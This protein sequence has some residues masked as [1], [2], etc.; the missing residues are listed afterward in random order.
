MDQSEECGEQCVGQEGEELTWE[1]EISFT[2]ELTTEQKDPSYEPNY[3][4]RKSA[5]EQS[6]EREPR[7]QRN[8]KTPDRLG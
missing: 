2:V 3:Y 5:E 4:F 8:K 1:D 6:L 7:P